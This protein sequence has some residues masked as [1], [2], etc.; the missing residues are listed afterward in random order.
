MGKV[1]L[2]LVIAFIVFLAVKGASRGRK[3][4][5]GGQG[6]K[7]ESMVACARCRVNL[8]RSE[9]LEADGSFYCSEE[10]RRLGTG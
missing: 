2:F 10:H 1:L 4:G 7:P 6:R 5:P 9:A 3:R 8:P